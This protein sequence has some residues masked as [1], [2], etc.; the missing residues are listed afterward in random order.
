MPCPPALVFAS[1]TCH[2]IVATP[3]VGLE[4]VSSNR[5]FGCL[6]AT[7]SSLPLSVR[8]SP[9]VCLRLGVSLSGQK[10]STLCVSSYFCFVEGE[11]D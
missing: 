11:G 6:P 5:I 8:G 4:G 2:G 3:K 10:K 9:Y 1:V 7:F